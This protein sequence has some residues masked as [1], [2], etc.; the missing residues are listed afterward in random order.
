MEIHQK[1]SIDNDRD[2]TSI[3]G[4]RS[5]TMQIGAWVLLV[6][7]VA[8]GGVIAQVIGS[9]LFVRTHWP[10][11][12]GDIVRSE[13]KST[14][15]ST[16]DRRPTLF[17]VEFEVEFD[18]K[19]AACNTGASWGVAIRFPCIG[20][21]RSAESSLGT[22]FDWIQ[23]HPAGSPARFYY[24]SKTGR[25]RFADES[26]FDTYPWGTIILFV[27][28]ACAASWL[29]NASR[30]RLDSLNTTVGDSASSSTNEE[31]TD[32]KLS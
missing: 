4:I 32:L 1:P 28:T 22:P 23:R 14:R 10:I 6:C 26:I 18:P 15:V 9:D 21:V 29:F 5:G 25:L 11:V 31:L 12:D 3:L 16:R 17:W 19:E 13:A 27:V 8:F 20:T 2:A 7:A 24:D 30:C